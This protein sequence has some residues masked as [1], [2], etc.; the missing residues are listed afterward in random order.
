[1]TAHADSLTERVTAPFH[2]AFK[3]WYGTMPE[4]VPF[5]VMSSETRGIWEICQWKT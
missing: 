2:R 1:M 4:G 3:R 5:A